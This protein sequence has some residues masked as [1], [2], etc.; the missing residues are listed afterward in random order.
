MVD[1]INP[2]ENNVGGS[3]TDASGEVIDELRWRDLNRGSYWISGLG[4]TNP[5]GDTLR[6]AAG[7][8][9]IDGMYCSLDAL[10][11]STAGGAAHY[12]AL[13]LRMNIDG[14][15]L[16]TGLAVVRTERTARLPTTG[17]H[18][19]PLAEYHF[20]GTSTY[21]IWDRRPNRITSISK[22]DTTLSSADA[23]VVLGFRPRALLLSN[24][25][26]PNTWTM[27]TEGVDETA[28]GDIDGTS[29]H[30]SPTIQSYGFSGVS[31][32]TGF[33]MAFQG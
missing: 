21:T 19:I 14:N 12:G 26:T 27:I 6:T 29:A 22:Y 7:S 15:S 31:S 13:F 11:D 30:S 9:V 5:S 23:T 33:F 28:Y 3:A 25:T 10:A 1:I 8:C 20:N 4:V 18:W 32:Q 24:L 16:A 2:S 17:T